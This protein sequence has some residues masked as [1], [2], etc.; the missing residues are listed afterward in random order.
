MS[1]NCTN[2]PPTPPDPP[3]EKRPRDCENTERERRRGKGS[4]PYRLGGRSGFGRPTA[5]VLSL[6]SAERKLPVHGNA[7]EVSV[8]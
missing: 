1:S 3:E 6:D 4:L 8:S 7:T 2:R 5:F